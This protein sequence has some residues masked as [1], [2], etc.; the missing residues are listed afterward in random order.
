[1]IE[2][3]KIQK[4]ISFSQY[5]DNMIIWIHWFG[6]SSGLEGKSFMQLKPLLRGGQIIR[7][8]KTHRP[9]S[10]R[11]PKKKKKIKKSE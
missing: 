7:L 11:L 10:N 1:M 6:V 9:P 3:L 2:K 5:F 8:L 4:N